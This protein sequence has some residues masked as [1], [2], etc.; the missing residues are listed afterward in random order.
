MQNFGKIKNA[1]NELVSEGIAIKDINSQ[2]LFKKYIK[3]VREN[4]ILKTQFLVITNIENRIETDRDKANQYLKEN[5]D[6]FSSFD[7]KKMIEANKNLSSFIALC[8]KG[9]LLNEGF[10]YNNKD[11]HE[12][13]SKL[14]FTKRTPNTIDII[15]EATNSIVDH[16]MNNK[17][18]ELVEAIDLPSSMISTIMVDKYNDKYADLTES[19][20]EVLK[21]LIE[22][23]DD[24]KKS[25]YTKIVR[26]CIDLINEKLGGSDLESKDKLLRVKDKLLNDKCEV[27]E[28][29]NESISKLIELKDNLSD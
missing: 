12:N 22:S 13:I 16:M 9:E 11:L 18:I 25:V 3:A 10:E 17:V 27:T 19:E 23:T 20:K 1:F 29:F 24:E 21:V 7:K 26:E 5:I 4:K 6:L 8:D 14:I 28:N 2:N 15:I